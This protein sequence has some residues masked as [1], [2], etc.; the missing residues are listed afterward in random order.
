MRAVILC[1]VN[2]PHI[3]MLYLYWSTFSIVVTISQLTWRFADCVS[4]GCLRTRFTLFVSLHV[5]SYVSMYVS[6]YIRLCFYRLFEEEIYHICVLL[7]VL[8]CA[9]ICVH[10][11]V[12]VCVLTYQ[13]VFLPVV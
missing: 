10:V 9:L 8:I 4:T 6:M 5:S 2:D 13:A 1:G 12:H 11:C 7:C 3:E